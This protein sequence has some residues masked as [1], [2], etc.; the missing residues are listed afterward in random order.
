MSV[1]KINSFDLTSIPK[2]TIFVLDANV[3]YYVHSGY[4]L[5]NDKRCIAYS[6][7]INNILKNGFT[8]SISVLTLQELL[9][10]IENKEYLLYCEANMLDCRKYTKK[11]YRKN[12]EQRNNLKLKFMAILAEL[13]VYNWQNA[14][15][16]TETVNKFVNELSFHSTDPMDYILVHNYNLENTVFVSGDKDF[17]SLDKVRVLTM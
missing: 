16:K 10:G 5:I 11:D 14:V 8:V 15:V 1:T 6:N 13:A 2:N 9:F 3:L 4:Y 12:K 17:Q 7:L